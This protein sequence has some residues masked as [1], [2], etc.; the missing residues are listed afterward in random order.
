[1]HKDFY[2]KETILIVDDDPD[3]LRTVGDIFLSEGYNVVRVSSAEK[4]LQEIY[5]KTPHIII[6]DLMLPGM[7]GFE[8]CK[9]IKQD[10]VLSHI[11][12]I[13]V[14]G[15][16]KNN[17]DKLR[18]LQEGA[19]DYI[20]KPFDPLEMLAK[21]KTF[22]RHTHY[23][24]D[25]NPITR[26]PGNSSSISAIEACIRQNR[27]F[28]VCYAD[29]DNFKAYNDTY[30]FEQ[31]D[32]VIKFTADIVKKCFY[33]M[34]LKGGFIGHLGGDDFIFIT[35][36]KKTKKACV[37]IIK[38]FDKEIVSFYPKSDIK[39]GHIVQFD[40]KGKLQKFPIMTI[41]IVVVHNSTRK[42]EHV[43][44]V[45]RIAAELKTYIKTFKGS[46]YIFDRRS[47]DK[48]AGKII[49][50]E[51]KGMAEKITNLKSI[52][53]SKKINIVLQPIISMNNCQIMGYEA[54]LRGPRGTDFENPELLF[55]LAKRGNLSSELDVLCIESALHKG[56]PIMKKSYIFVN[57]K[58]ETLGDV[59][60]LKKVFDPW[61]TKIKQA[62]GIIIEVPE[63]GIYYISK[64]IEEGIEYL[65]EIGVGVSIDDVGKGAMSLRD[66]A[67]IRP[68]FI[69]IDIS[70]VRSVNTDNDR[71]NMLNS[72]L[73]FSKWLNAK[74]VAEGVEIK[75]E[76]EYLLKRKVYY[77]QGYLFARPSEE[78]VKTV[79][80][81][82]YK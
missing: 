21:I 28:A 33:K 39:K 50:K 43:G 66:I 19:V 67:K 6:L 5:T 38:L 2:E 54:L 8:L 27:P 70:L 18:G 55:S 45:S 79:N 52:I 72:L 48:Y 61:K 71:Q 40:R 25:A 58:A 73:R 37:D 68:D 59:N 15:K 3:M 31:G 76:Y 35:D 56:V 11:P 4:A 47:E 32:K 51:A 65:R 57:V 81:E 16:L 80:M 44:H 62:K 75:E 7:D 36:I 69:K 34:R 20:T 10:I 60:L 26:L 30:G 41:S 49:S 24:L 22:L 12:I 29:L 42:V 78:I 13:I 74:V 9:I 23:Q 1:M 14:S 46:N 64:G 63:E 17:K 82:F 53:E 77:G